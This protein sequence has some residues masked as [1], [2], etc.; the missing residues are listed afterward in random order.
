MRRNQTDL[1]L[2][3]GRIHC[4]TCFRR[5]L[6]GGGPGNFSKQGFHVFIA[7]RLSEHVHFVTQ[8]SHHFTIGEAGP[9]CQRSITD[10]F[11]QRNILQPAN[12]TVDETARGLRRSSRHTVYKY[13]NADII[14]VGICI[15]AW[16]IS[17]VQ[18]H[19]QVHS[20]AESQN[21]FDAEVGDFVSHAIVDIDLQII[22]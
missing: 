22:S 4:P 2:H 9:D 8:Q 12:S 20:A 1:R 14:H 5:N 17:I 21:S 10:T 11:C 7:E 3:L 15:S 19:S 16:R 18:R 13:A 6:S